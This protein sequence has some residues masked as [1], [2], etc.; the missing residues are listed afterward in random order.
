MCLCVHVFLSA[1]AGCCECK[2]W[3]VA[4]HLRTCPTQPRARTPPC[5]RPQTK[6]PQEMQRLLSVFEARQ[7]MVMPTGDGKAISFYDL[8]Q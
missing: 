7:K 3:Q 1:G 8:Y 2:G 4:L 6:P 5:P